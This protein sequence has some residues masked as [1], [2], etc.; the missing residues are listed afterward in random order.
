MRG[1]AVA[2]E[3]TTYEYGAVDHREILEERQRAW[4]RFVQFLTWSVA[5]IALTLILLAIF[6]V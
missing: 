2:D 1:Q 3:Q 6:L 5:G 4:K